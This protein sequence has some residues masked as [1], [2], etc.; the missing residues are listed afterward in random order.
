MPLE[1]L[2]KLL[3]HDALQQLGDE[4]ANTLGYKKRHNQDWFDENDG[5]ISSLLEQKRSAFVKTVGYS[6]PK[7]A[8]D[9]Y[10]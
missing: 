3:K 4:R 8:Q 5:I 9:L 1:I 2:S 10:L 6:D 7:L